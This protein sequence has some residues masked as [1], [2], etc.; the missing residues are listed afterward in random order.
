VAQS[1]AEGRLLFSMTHSEIDPKVFASAKR[2]QLHL[3]DQIGAKPYVSPMLPFPPTLEL[4]AA[5]RAVAA[6][7]AQRLVPT[8]DTR[9]GL[10]RV[11]GFKGELAEHHAAH[12][13]QMA[14]IGLPDLAR[15]WGP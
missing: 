3:L 8:S 10:L 9:V 2:S 4:P 14:V 15:R 11:Q 6:G 12:L 13:T 5:A 7:R 1:A